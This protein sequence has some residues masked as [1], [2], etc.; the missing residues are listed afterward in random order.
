M[1]RLLS[2]RH[3]RRHRLRTALALVSVALGVAA[4]LAMVALNRGVLAAFAETARQRSG[5]AQLLLRGGRAGVAREIADEASH[6]RGVVAA[7]PIVARI[8]HVTEPVQL[9]L[10]L[11]GVDPT[12]LP[13]AAG[14]LAKE[15][16]DQL[17]NPLTLLRGGVPIFLPSELANDPKLAPGEAVQ[18]AAPSGFVSARIAGTIKS[19]GLLATFGGN[20]AAARLDDAIALTS[21]SPNVDRIQLFLAPDASVESVRDSVSELLRG[22]AEIVAPE[23]LAREYDATLGSFRIALRFLSL[24]SL[25]IAAFLVHSTL[26]MALAE[27]RRELSIARCVGL[28]AARLRTL[29]VLEGGVIGGAGALLGAPLGWVLARAMG[30]VFWQTVGGTFD[31]IE[32]TITAPSAGE[33]AFGVL[34]GLVAALVA[35]VPPAFEAARRAPLAGLTA[36]RTEERDGRPRRGRIL[37]AVVLAAAAIAGYAFDGFG[38]EHAGYAVAALLALSIAFGAHP[39]LAFALRGTRRP[40]LRWLGPAGRLARDHCERAVGPTSLTVVAI[41]LGFGLVYSTDVLVKSYVRM[42]DRWFAANVGEE[43]LVM[44]DDLLESG[45]QGTSFD[46]SFAEE[47]KRVP[48]I[49]YADG[50]R[51]S[52]VPY[53]GE[54][55]LLFALDGRSPPEAGHVLWVDGSAADLPRFASGDGVFVSEGFAHRFGV[56][57][58]EKLEL[59]SPDG[60]RAFEV[61]AVVEDYMWPRGSIW[62]DNTL[63]RTAF[64]DDEVQEFGITLDHT[65]PLADVKRDVERLVAPRFAAIVVESETVRQNVMK[66]VQQYWTLLFAQEGLAVTVAFLGMLHTLLISVLLRRREIALLRSLGAP[67]RMVGAMLRTEGVL[68]GLA[69]GTIGACFGAATATIALRMMSLEEQGFRVVPRPSL[70]IAL[71]TIVAAGFTGW[72]AGLLPGRRAA[73]AAPR[74]ALLDTMA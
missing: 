8:V 9:R 70:S 46:A 2:L 1:L 23:E 18:I 64:H 20:V 29:L 32:P 52:R 5:G 54:R 58:G 68:L 45:L 6:V 11:I 25:L 16:I 34:A 71:L 56:G 24:L 69:G 12:R 26:S 17:A 28:S 48:G 72:L 60:P 47:L 51:F 67:L 36:A 3:F 30:A 40:I 19:E 10:L 7:V 43:L 74:A 21:K 39:L 62:I 31:R 13:P 66:I 37:V 38:I 61:L 33:I 63:Y 73:R 55:V 50:L 49:L 53:R 4:F 42:L 59:T 14:L 65:R 41:S 44:G 27:R 15:A 22:R 57:R 35:V